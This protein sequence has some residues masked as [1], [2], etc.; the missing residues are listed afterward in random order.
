[1]EYAIAHGEQDSRALHESADGVQHLIAAR[2][3]DLRGLL[4]SLATYSR[5]FR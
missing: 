5:D 4:G 1:M 3:R 2:L